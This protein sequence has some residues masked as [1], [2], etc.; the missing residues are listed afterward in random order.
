LVDEFVDMTVV[1]VVVVDTVVA[2][3]AI[4]KEEEEG[5]CIVVIDV[6][7]VKEWDI[8]AGTVDVDVDA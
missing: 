8:A 5:W 6:V 3:V 1:V 2:V 4:V 7:R